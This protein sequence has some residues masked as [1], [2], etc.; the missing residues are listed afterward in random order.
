MTKPKSRFSTV[1]RVKKHQ[2]KLTQQQLLQIEQSHQQEKEL[3]DRLQEAREEAVKESYGTGRAK[4]TDLQTHRAFI[5]HLTRQ[6]HR[7][8]TKVNE[9]KER[10]NAKREELTQRAQARQMV[11]KLEERSKEQT[12]RELDRKEQHIMDELAQRTT[13]TKE[14]RLPQ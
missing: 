9:M 6:I 14:G 11:E 13:T 2:E 7:Q 4:A 12:L 3:L 5:F 10:E 1:L 8:E